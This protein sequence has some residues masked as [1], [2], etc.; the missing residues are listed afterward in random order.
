M[1]VKLVSLGRSSKYNAPATQVSRS[2][3][4]TPVSW[5]SWLH[6]SCSMATERSATRRGEPSPS[7]KLEYSTERQ[8]VIEWSSK[9]P[10]VQ[11]RRSEVPS[12]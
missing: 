7:L 11:V 10:E 5:I 3:T 2:S 1:V 4:A 8:P 6:C 9:S 12:T